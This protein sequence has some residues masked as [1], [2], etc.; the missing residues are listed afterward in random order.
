MQGNAYAGPARA[1]ADRGGSVF[2]GEKPMR[3]VLENMAKKLNEY[4][5]ASLMQLWQHFA[6]QVHEFE[7]T[8]RWEEA[9]LA[10][11]LIQAVHWKNQLFNYRLALSA[12]P[13]DK[14]DMPLLPDFFSSR[15]KSAPKKAD[16]PRPK[17]TVLAFPGNSP[18]PA[19]AGTC[20]GPEGGADTP[21]GSGE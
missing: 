17:A 18:S 11:C 12:H 9:A 19:A 5:E 6:S 3:R 20:S 8:R 14:A 21:P 2:S 10:L 13:A 4:D 7:P 1:G 15:K 16:A